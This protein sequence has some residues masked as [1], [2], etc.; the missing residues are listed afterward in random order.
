MKSINLLNKTFGRWFVMSRAD[1][2][3]NGQSQWLCRC[4]CDKKK[5]LKSIVLRRG[6]SKSCGC[7]K[8]ELNIVRST[9]H[10]H[11]SSTFISPTYHSWAGMKARCNN[12][13]HKSYKNYGGRGITVCEK[14]KT[15]SSFL[16]DMGIKP[17]GKSLDRIDNN[18]NYCPKNCK[19]STALEQANNKQSS[20]QS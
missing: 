5:I 11:S 1:N 9:K 3:S 17:E 8:S 4:E 6:I 2:T 15:F 20:K 12:P 14:W 13:N 10:N 18:G 7:L 16:T 19:W